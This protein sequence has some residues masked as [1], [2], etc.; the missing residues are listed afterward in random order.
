MLRSYSQEEL[1]ELDLEGQSV[2]EGFSLGSLED[3][4]ELYRRGTID[5][6][7]LDRVKGS[8]YGVH[9][10]SPKGTRQSISLFRTTDGNWLVHQK[11]QV[12]GYGE[13]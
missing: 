7:T 3:A 5:L 10:R 4:Y 13:D 6:R 11:V 8:Y 9:Y 1:F 12:P 2:T